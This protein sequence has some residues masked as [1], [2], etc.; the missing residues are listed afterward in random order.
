MSSA[1]LEEVMTQQ[2]SSRPQRRK[3]ERRNVQEDEDVEND[4][5][6]ADVIIASEAGAVRRPAAPVV[7]VRDHVVPVSIVP[8]LPRLHRVLQTVQYVVPVVELQELLASTTTATSSALPPLLSEEERDSILKHEAER[9][10]ASGW[11]WRAGIVPPP[12]SSAHQCMLRAALRQHWCNTIEYDNTQAKKNRNSASTTSTLVEFTDQSFGLTKDVQGLPTEMFYRAAYQ[13]LT[14]PTDLT[15]S[16]PM[17]EVAATFSSS[18]PSRGKR[19]ASG[20]LVDPVRL[21]SRETVL[22]ISKSQGVGGGGVGLSTS[23]DSGFERQACLT[24]L[25]RLRTRAE[26]APEAPQPYYVSYAQPSDRS[27]AFHALRS[28]H[29]QQADI[30]TAA[31][32][33]SDTTTTGTSASSTSSSPPLRAGG[34]EYLDGALLL[35]VERRDN[36]WMSSLLLMSEVIPRLSHDISSTRAD[37]WTA[38]VRAMMTLTTRRVLAMYDIGRAERSPRMRLQLGDV[39]RKTMTWYYSTPLPTD[40][41]TTLARLPPGDGG[42][43]ADLAAAG[44][45][46]HGGK[47]GRGATVASAAAAVNGNS[48]EEVDNISRS[49]TASG[50]EEKVEEAITTTTTAYD[51]E[52]FEL[53]IAIRS[54]IFTQLAQQK[55]GV[56]GEQCLEIIRHFMNKQGRTMRSA[57]LILLLPR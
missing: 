12:P 13:P 31:A 50:H 26:P 21:V 28:H 45:E 18:S 3:H 34:L 53:D 5:G 44:L 57:E 56:E 9:M 23:M 52:R 17:D 1:P 41:M 19:S 43:W 42:C 40:V 11:A 7:V 2:I 49:S 20:I 48:E 32:T 36:P 22:R 15:L 37:V 35:C 54:G 46:L 27:T 33:P 29:Q 14:S 39:T 47:W 4:A 6:T 38:V 30:L 16:R 10:E 55:D 8:L 51:W 25:V 24:N